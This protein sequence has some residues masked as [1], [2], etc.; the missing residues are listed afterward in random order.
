MDCFLHFQNEKLKA[1]LNEETRRRETILMQTYESK[2]KAI[3]DAKDE[4]LTTATNRTLE[5]QNYLLMAEKESKNWEKQTLANEAMVNDLNKKLNQLAR[6][7]KHEEDAESICNG[8]HDHNDDGRHEK[9]VCKMCHVRSTCMLMLP[10][11]H[12]CCCRACEDPYMVDGQNVPTKAQMADYER[13]ASQKSWHKAKDCRHKKEHGGET[14]GGNSNQANHLQSPKEFA[15]VIESFLTTNVVDWWK[16]KVILR[17]TSGKD[18]VLS[19]VLHVPNITKNLISGL[20]LS[21]KGFKLVIESD[22][23]VITKGGV[24]VGKG[25][26]DEGLFKLSVVTDDNVINNNNAGTSIAS[27]YMINPSF[28]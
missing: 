11:R 9:M 14:S 7:K 22:K 13:A 26:F 16:G 20:I 23:F 21:N 15:R 18:F 3:L 12:L 5:L 2:M 25:Y 6:N 8:G 4:V 27:V 19:N 10:C 1:V 24:Y 17:L 28:L